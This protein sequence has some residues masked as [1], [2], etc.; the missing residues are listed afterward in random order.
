VHAVPHRVDE[1]DLVDHELDQE[2]QDGTAMTHHCSTN[3]GASI[4]PTRPATPTSATTPYTLMPDD[5]PAPMAV[6]MSTAV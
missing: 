6:P 4:Q 1:R 5:H 3:D 2:Q